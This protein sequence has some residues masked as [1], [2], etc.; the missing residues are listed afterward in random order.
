[1]KEIDRTGP[2]TDPEMKAFLTRSGFSARCTATTELWYGPRWRMGLPL[3]MAYLQ[4]IEK[5]KRQQAR[6]T[7]LQRLQRSGYQFSRERQGWVHESDPTGP[8]MTRQQAIGRCG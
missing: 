3:G 8:V 1:M 4:Q 5:L 7:E 6:M 2:V